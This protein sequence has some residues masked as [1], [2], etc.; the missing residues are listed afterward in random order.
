M[1]KVVKRLVV[2]Q[3]H[4]MLFILIFKAKENLLYSSSVLCF[5]CSNV[6]RLI[7]LLKNKVL[8]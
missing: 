5:L 7:F 3:V 4:F 6:I 2:R 8:N 1:R